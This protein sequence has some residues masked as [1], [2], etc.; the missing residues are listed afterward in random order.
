MHLR[1]IYLN[2][3]RNIKEARLSFSSGINCIAGMN[4]SGKTN[5][6]DAIYYLS[7]TKSFF[8]T[9][10]NIVV[11]H[12]SIAFSI[13]GEYV[14]EDNTEESIH[15]TFGKNGEK[16]VK[17]NDKPY[18]RMSDHIGLIPV[19]M[20]SPYDTSLINDSG[21]ERRR[22]L[23]MIL[24]QTDKEYLRRVQ[25]YNQLLVQRNKL[26][27]QNGDNRELLILMSEQMAPHADYIFQKRASFCDDVIPVASDFYSKLSGG[28][29]SINI[30]YK[31]EL[32]DSTLFDLH[33]ESLDKDLILKHTTA[34]IHR[35]DMIFSLDGHQI[36]RFGSQGQ[37]K[38]F[39]ISLKL[40]QYMITKKG[41][42]RKPILLLDDIFDKLDQ[43][44]VERLLLLTAGNDFG[45]I[46]ITDS[47]KIRLDDILGRIGGDNSLFLVQNGHLESVKQ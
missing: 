17:R 25:S 36:R 27:K 22:F 40:S 21:E 13:T 43:G 3:F 12:D 29:E 26:L 11:N 33:K 14:R 24:S 8:T 4:G 23:N 30:E 38:S 41:A 45:Q 15:I 20:V 10:D 1:N 16:L 9:A 37:Q 18:S 32:Q 7:V 6:L 5:L 47:N 31:S 46:F 42:G 2:N 35:D 28:N 44:R 39:L 34:G 19:V